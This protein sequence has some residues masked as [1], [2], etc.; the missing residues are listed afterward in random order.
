MINTPAKS[1]AAEAIG[2]FT[3]VFCGVLAIVGVKIAGITSPAVSWTSIAFAHGL[4]IAVM[5]AALGAV[6]GGHFNPAVTFGFVITRRMNVGRG[7]LYWIAQLLGAS[8]AGILI[9]ELFGA[10]MAANG[11]PNVA[12]AISPA[13]GTVVEAVTTFFLVLVVFGTAV[14][15]RARN[16]DFPF[17]IGLT[18]AMGILATGALTGGAMNPARAFGPALASGHWAH[19]LVY[20]IGPLIGGGC[21]AAVQHNFLME[22]TAPVRSARAREQELTTIGTNA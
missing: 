16:R 4:A 5:V 18:V 9:A 10:G 14:D 11:T 6:S 20:W 22:R 19:Q 2:T 7:M 13:A 21:A 1:F 15:P 3:L 8:A 12:A 17:A